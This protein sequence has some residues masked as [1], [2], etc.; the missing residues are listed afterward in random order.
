[1]LGKIKNII[2]TL[3]SHIDTKMVAVPAVGAIMT[4]AS[5]VTSFASEG[6]ATLPNVAIT[7]DMLQ[8]LV[9]GVVANIAVVL[10]VGLGLFAIMIG[11]RLIPGLLNR[12]IRG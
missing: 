12:F 4:V 7:T 1:M 2:S 10:P 3:K 5:S 6:S 8:P 11:I 9:E